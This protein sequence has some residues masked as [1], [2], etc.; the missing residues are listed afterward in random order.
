MPSSQAARAKIVGPMR[1]VNEQRS[2][3]SSTNNRRKIVRKSATIHPTSTQNRW[4]IDLGPIWA[5]PKF[6][7][8]PPFQ[9]VWKVDIGPILVDLGLQKE[10]KLALNSIQNQC[11]IDAR[12]SYAKSM[13]NDAKMDPKWMPKSAKIKKKAEKRH[14][15]NRCQNLMR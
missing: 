3:E 9:L 2:D 7:G 1:S 10:P 14:A 11:K 13:E 12:K 6:S 15:E 5:P 8:S 4:K